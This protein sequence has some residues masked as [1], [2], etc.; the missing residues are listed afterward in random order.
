MSA[1]PK[2]DGRRLYSSHAQIHFG[3]LWPVPSQP[4]AARSTSASMPY[5]KVTWADIQMLIGYKRYR[6]ARMRHTDADRSTALSLHTRHSRT[7]NASISSNHFHYTTP[8]L[9]DGSM[10]RTKP[11][12]SCA[13]ITQTQ[14]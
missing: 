10:D 3:R 2:T 5:S 7:P 11:Y 13:M 12:E 1:A 4:K 14:R 8:N 6:G 9:P